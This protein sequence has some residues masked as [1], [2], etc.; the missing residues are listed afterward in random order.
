LSGGREFIEWLLGIALPC[1]KLTGFATGANSEGH[2]SA[3]PLERLIHPWFDL[4]K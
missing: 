1:E 3:V 2:L 4:R